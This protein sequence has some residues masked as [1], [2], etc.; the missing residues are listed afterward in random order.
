MNITFTLNGVSRS[1]ETAPESL[2]RSSCSGSDSHLFA[3]A[4][5]AM[6]SP[7]AIPSSLITGR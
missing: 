4:M 5:T 1:V 7:A 6:A 3:T 2:C